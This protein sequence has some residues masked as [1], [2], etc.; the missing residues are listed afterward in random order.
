MENPFGERI[1]DGV[2]DDGAAAGD[3]AIIF[4][5]PVYDNPI[6]YRQ[7]PTTTQVNL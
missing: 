7:L 3:D 5:N 2:N 4:D 1:E 6:I